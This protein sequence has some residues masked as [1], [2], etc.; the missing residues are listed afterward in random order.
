M[1]EAERLR[2]YAK[3]LDDGRLSPE[4][5]KRIADLCSAKIRGYEESIAWLSNS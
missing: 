1:T 2:Y 3:Y 4:E 5:R